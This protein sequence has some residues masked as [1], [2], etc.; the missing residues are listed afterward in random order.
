[1]ALLT[2]SVEVWAVERL[3][4]CARNSRTHSAQQVA[5][6][7]GSISEFGFLNPV[8]VDPDGGLIAGHARV[9]AA[10]KLGLIEVPVI[11]LG[12]LTK[13]QKQAFMLADNQLALN[14]GWDEA[15]LRL[16]LEALTQA[17]F[18][19]PILGFDQQ[20]LD[21]LLKD[22]SRRAPVDPDEAPA[23][24]SE[25]VNQL[26]DLWELGNHRLLCGDGTTGSDL[27]RVLGGSSSD[28]IFTDPPFSCAYIGKTPS[29]LTIANDN[30]G[31][32]FP[33]FLAAACQSMLAVNTGAIYI[34]MSSRELHHLFEAFSQAGGHWSTFVIWAKNTFTLGRAD[35]QRQY[36]QILY[37]WKEG[38]PHYWCGDRNQGD[39]WFVNKPHRNDVHPTM[40]PVELVERA[41]NN[42]CRK[43][44]LVLDPFAGA[45]STLLAAERTGRRACVVEIDPQYADVILRRWQ[46]Y[47]G[48][49]ARLVL[50]GQT[51]AEVSE[52]RRQ[53]A[54]EQEKQSVARQT[55]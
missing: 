53:R 50:G 20:D 38:S 1:M 3:I 37:G 8:L 16:E 54:A 25:A 2:L 9:L 35:Y 4:P 43:G 42:S 14:A 46:T 47:S 44:D 21:R 48:H 33:A 32:Q 28:M 10:R 52:Q 31:D 51:F 55:V 30:L 22:L 29:R 27:E 40:K 39:V 7:A 41:I 23:L 11:V 19:V 24:Q 13:I 45:G 26:G 6:I 15:M 34:C 17:G 36:E 18:E 12:H 5:Q 49:V